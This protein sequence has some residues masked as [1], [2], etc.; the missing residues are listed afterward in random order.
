LNS[1][2]ATTLGRVGWRRFALPISL[3]LNLFLLALIG[4]H[5]LSA[6]ENTSGLPLGRALMRAEASL[7]PED[8]A[9]FRAVMQRDAPRYM[10]AARQL[11]DARQ[12]LNREIT[13]DRF[14]PAGTRKALTAWR[15]ASNH[16][17]DEFGGTLIDALT[18]VSP[19]G[20][21]KLVAARPWAH[22]AAFRP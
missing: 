14:D 15:V 6:Y 16:F 22:R 8:A 7:S 5:L 10:E 11:K 3:G 17:L 12:N 19:E 1:T 20:R 4:G 9:A 2:A 21:R 13:A 18:R